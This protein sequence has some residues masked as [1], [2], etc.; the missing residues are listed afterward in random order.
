MSSSTTKQHLRVLK[1]RA[2]FL[3]NRISKSKR[4]LSFDKAERAALLW[5]IGLISNNQVG[6][7]VS[8]QIIVPSHGNDHQQAG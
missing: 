5:V 3:G 2:E 7:V 4:D 1:R 8:S 6:D